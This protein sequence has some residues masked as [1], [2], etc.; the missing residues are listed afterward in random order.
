MTSI[1]RGPHGSKDVGS[2]VAELFSE[3]YKD[4]KERNI[5]RMDEEF[6][7]LR[8]LW[9]GVDT[10]ISPSSR[11]SILGIM[12]QILCE[13]PRWK[14]AAAPSLIK[15]P[16]QVSRAVTQSSKFFN[17]VLAH[18][19]VANPTK[20][21]KLFR[22]KGESEKKKKVA[23]TVDAKLSAYEAAMESWMNGTGKN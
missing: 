14:V 8:R 11:K 1:S 12:A 20:V 17:E 2:F 23:S 15:D 3:A 16:V 5:I 4:Y 21:Q 9:E 13:V 10:R 6:Q 22:C 7:T 19:A 18:P